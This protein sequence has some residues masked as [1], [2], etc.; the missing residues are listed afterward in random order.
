MSVPNLGLLVADEP[1]W[2]IGGPA[3][4]ILGERL[5]LASRGTL[6]RVYWSP[7]GMIGYGDVEVLEGPLEGAWTYLAQI[8]IRMLSAL[9]Q[10]ARA[11]L[12]AE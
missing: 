6:V 10:L 9:E 3:A 8:D 1:V 5:G 12:E 4:D 7:G 11:A 2:K